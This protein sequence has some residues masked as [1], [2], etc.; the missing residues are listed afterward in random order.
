MDNNINIDEDFNIDVDYI[1]KLSEKYKHV[2]HPL[3]MDELPK[4]LEENEDLEALYKIITSE[5]NPLILAQDYKEVGNDYFKDGIKYFEDAVISYTKG[6]D[7]LNNYLKSVDIQ[8]KKNNNNNHNNNHNNHNNNNSGDVTCTYP[9]NSNNINNKTNGDVHKQNGEEINDVESN[10]KIKNKHL[11]KNDKNKN[12]KIDINEVKILLSDLYCNRAIIHYKKKRYIKCLDDCKNSFSFNNKKYKSLYFSILSS[13][14][15]E[16]YHDACKHINKFDELL[17][18]IEGIE[19]Y[20]NIQEYEKLKKDIFKKYEDYLRRK[21]KAQDERKKI[22]EQE[23]NKINQIQ[24]I[25]KKRNI[26]TLSNV[27]DNNNN[28]IPVLYLDDNMYIHFTVFLIYYEFNIIETILDFSES[29]C[30]MD[31]YDIIKKRPDNQILYCYIEFPD[32]IFY[33][34]NNYF[35]MCDIMNKIK[36]FTHILAIHIIENDVANMN[37]KINKNITYL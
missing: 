8:N 14:N 23:K 1:K 5:D 37:F 36:M 33:M 4:N 18:N 6:I 7:I 20:I 22:E 25:L 16:M 29:Q 31:Y 10:D 15:M 2:D 27:Y 30:I 17:K 19:S 13:N 35:Y 26:Q 9:C 11:L 12:I 3:F 28:I 34:I 24:D 21:K 32:E